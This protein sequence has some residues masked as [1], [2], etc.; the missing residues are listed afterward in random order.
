MSSW[1]G[2]LDPTQRA[3]VDAWLAR[4]ERG[5]AESAAEFVASHGF[6]GEV[7]RSVLA[8]LDTGG[9]APAIHAP[10]I[11]ERFVVQRLLGA[12]GMGTVHLAWDTRLEREVALKRMR[13][14]LLGIDEVRRRFEIEARA[15]STLSHPNLCPVHDVGEVDGVPFIVMPFVEGRTLADRIADARASEAPPV[16][17]EVVDLLATLALAI[18][19]AHEHGLVHRDL[20]PGNVIIRPDGS[21]V[22]LDFGL[23][24]DE[25]IEGLTRSGTQPGTREYM[26]PEQVQ[27]RGRK[28]DRRT[29]VWALGVMLYECLT[30]H[31]PFRGDGEHEL[32]T[33]ILAAR[34]PRPSRLGRRVP[35][36]LEV[37]IGVA[38]APEPERRYQ[39]ARAL[40]EDLQRFRRHEPIHA[41]RASLG[42]RVRRF[43][44][45][46]PWAATTLGAIAVALVI[47]TVLFRS[48]ETNLRRFDALSRITKLGDAARSAAG[49]VPAEP[50][51]APRLR[52]W[53]DDYGP[54]L[55]QMAGQIDRQIDELQATLPSDSDAQKASGTGFL[56]DA[57]LEARPAMLAFGAPGGLHERMRARLWW[58]E[59][60]TRLSVDEHRAAWDEALRA[61]RDGDG[62]T[63]H[64]AY[65]GL[66]IAPQ[67]GLVPLGPDPHSKLYEFYDLWTAE[68]GAPIPTRDPQSGEL[69][70]DDRSGIV[71]VLVPSIA[72]WLGAQR[73]DPAAPCYDKDYASDVEAEDTPRRVQLAPFLLGKHEVTQ[74][75]W[76]RH[77][78]ANPSRYAIGYVDSTSG[79][80]ITGRNP[81]EQMSW[82]LADRW[83]RAAGLRLP[84]ND[85][86]E[87]A[88]RAGA[89][90][91][92]SFGD[93][94]RAIGR[95][96]NV[97]D[98]TALRWEPEWRSMAAKE[99]DGVM[100]NDDGHLL[101][102]P[103]G[104]F[105][106][107]AFGLRDMH[108][109]VGEWTAQGQDDSNRFVR[110]GMFDQR[111]EWARCWR[112]VP[113][114]VATSHPAVGLRVARDLVPR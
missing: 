20:K 113:L 29:D 77:G 75:Q 56:L 66:Q 112:R 42:L 62:V 76:T 14:E 84:T 8:H 38:L 105:A 111:V 89:S 26:A 10:P 80:T 81:A 15:A 21:P 98:A 30:L 94:P 83:S 101:H 1:T 39:T 37:V 67:P 57:L 4:A 82:T 44:R 46:E 24:H 25:S 36:D 63:V 35:R 23:V 19:H 55:L 2:G 107:N 50:S 68:R 40:A 28:V 34:P 106:P 3:I 85:E 71:L 95:F 43:C 103:V 88:C 48:A 61:I 17:A 73:T 109:N 41:R 54:P 52:A 74:S 99:Q 110:G 31:R 51:M 59:N 53:L 100:P 65:R 78:D 49:L 27:P 45:R 91:P 92:Y 60:V 72:T 13:P 18:D 70:L 69:R 90:D 86:W 9:G 6:V 93:D 12:G 33:S 5:E 87:L 16:A 32:S 104:S 7:L 79:E 47:V 114:N 11:A 22:V 58:A 97:V 96:G 108:G 102:A 64:A